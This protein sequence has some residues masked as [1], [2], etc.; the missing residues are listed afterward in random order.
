MKKLILGTW[1]RQARRVARRLFAALPTALRFGL[2]RR[3]MNFAPAQGGALELKIADTQAELEQC[4]ALLHDAY[5][6][7]G[8]MRPHASGLRVTPYHALPT[9]TTLCA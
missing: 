3:A 6:A 8:F 9:T 5:V 2:Y 1:R 4:F 7:S